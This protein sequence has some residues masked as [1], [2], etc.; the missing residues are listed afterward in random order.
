MADFTSNL[1]LAIHAKDLTGPGFL[2]ASVGLRTFAAVGATAMGGLVAGAVKAAASYQSLVTQVANNTTMGA[3]GAAQMSAAIQAMAAKT[4]APLDQ[5]AQGWMHITDLGF[6]AAQAQQILNAAQQSAVST[7]GNAA[8]AANVL[9]NAMHEY[10][11]SANQAAGY[12]DVLHLAAAQG[13]AT[14]EQFVDGGGK[15]IAMA[16]NLGVPL[17]QVA[18]AISAL[19]RHGQDVPTAATSITS[20]LSHIVNPAKQAKAELARLTLSSG[21]DLLGDFSAQGLRTRGLPG[22][23]ADLRTAL[24]NSKGQ[25]DAS[26]LFKIMP[27]KV[28]GLGAQVL[29]GSGTADYASILGSLQQ[30]MAG[31]TQ[32]TMQAFARTT[33][34]LGF[35]LGVLRNKLQLLGISL[36]TQ[37]VPYATQAA[38]W[39]GAHLPQAVSTLIAR[40]APLVQDGL[41]VGRA[42]L[43]AAGSLAHTAAGLIQLVAPLLATQTRLGLTRKAAA[44]VGTALAVLIPA[45]VAVKVGL[46]AWQVAQ[47][48]WNAAQVIG[49][50]ALT[51]WRGAVVVA[52]AAV[53]A[54]SAVNAGLSLAILA[55]RI[56]LVQQTAQQIL[57]ATWTGIVRV[58]T[59]AWT[60]ALGL[61]RGAMLLTTAGGAGM[62][63]GMIAFNTWGLAVKGATAAW[64]AAQ[65]LLNAAL[66]ANPLGLVTI[67]IAALVAGVIWAYKN[68]GWFH[69]AV[70]TAWTFL[71]SVFAPGLTT[72]ANALKNI[73]GGAISW[74]T[75]KIQGLIG[76]F[77]NLLGMV[78]KIPVVHQA[79][80][81]AYDAGAAGTSHTGAHKRGA[82]HPATGAVRTLPTS[83][84]A[85]R[86]RGHQQAGDAATSSGHR[87]AQH[88]AARHGLTARQREAAQDVLSGRSGTSGKTRARTPLQ[89]AQLTYATDNALWKQGRRSNSQVERDINA[90]AALD[91]K[92]AALLQAQFDAEV[93]RRNDAIRHA[94]AAQQV[95]VAHHNEAI[96]HH[97]AVQQ[98]HV[99]ILAAHKAAAAQRTKNHTETVTL[100]AQ[101]Q[102]DNTR[103]ATDMRDHKYADARTMIAALSGLKQRLEMGSGVSAAQAQKDAATYADGLLSRL[104]A[105][106]GL[107]TGLKALV[108]PRA[109]SGF[110][111]SIYGYTSRQRVGEGVALG[112][113]LVTFG[114]RPARDPAQQM[115]DK[116]EKQVDQLTQQNRALQT[117]IAVM[118]D[119]RD[120]TVRVGDI[121]QSRLR[122]TPGPGNPGVPGNPL[123]PVG[124]ATATR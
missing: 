79:L 46:I 123:R 24:T 68:V 39:L 57:S 96:R 50:T 93:T 25:V 88:A 73:L 80:A 12:M 40:L 90:L 28:G 34:T 87:T 77:G 43:A 58:A 14:L 23:L 74:V 3:R 59:T 62:V 111:R 76:F 56:G 82:H 1:F 113:T 78:G 109:G 99:Q 103:F 54:Y 29:T 106:T 55:V 13:N 119:G 42:F 11:A 10:G 61:L 38:T 100:R 41:S 118:E 5:L 21:V 124:L 115:I 26:E 108:A 48:A 2:G 114:G 86:L 52:Q 85:D 71:S 72:V 84:L 7:N 37:L 31:K 16:A 102:A 64:T 67:A 91:P 17:T 81:A 19:T 105:K 66:D 44:Q 98:H 32:P 8:D 30:T 95:R 27:A 6:N 45:V 18:A 65:W 122:P 33:Q 63:L 69:D 110:R 92:K 83:A 9:A 53:A 70:N 36:G 94:A 51:L 15:A 116:L 107:V 104:D 4:S 22:V 101:Y 60:V 47:V 75:D 20:M 89:A 120:A 117:I 49:T 112:Q 121:L 97:A 35:Q